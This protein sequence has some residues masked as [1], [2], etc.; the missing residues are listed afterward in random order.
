MEQLGCNSVPRTPPIGQP[1]PKVRHPL[2]PRMETFCPVPRSPNP[3]LEG[4]SMAQK[5]NDQ[6]HD[7]DKPQYPADAITATP[8]IVTAAVIPEAA[9]EQQD[10]QDDHQNQ[11]HDG[12]SSSA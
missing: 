3:A 8:A 7:Q 1:R 4:A 12:F 5:V 9:S 6:H 2:V 10:H 11:F